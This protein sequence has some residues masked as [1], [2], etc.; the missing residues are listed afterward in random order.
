VWGTARGFW[1]HMGGCAWR[2]AARLACIHRAACA[3]CGRLWCRP[4]A[5]WATAARAVAM[6]VG[7][8]SIPCANR[9][10]QRYM[11]EVRFRFHNVCG[12]RS[13]RPAAREAYPRAGG[14]VCDLLVLAETNCVGVGGEQAERQWSRAWLNG[15]ET[16]GLGLRT[17][18]VVLRAVWLCLFQS[19]SLKPTHRTPGTRP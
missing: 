2:A 17:L 13:D 12:V 15:Y 5:V 8:A 18:K 3:D 16:L 9:R 4:R 14:D 1:R 10:G 19:A 6:R 11:Q 7:I